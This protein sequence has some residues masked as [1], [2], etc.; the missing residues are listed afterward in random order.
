MSVYDGM[1]DSAAQ[2]SLS[3]VLDCSTCHMT[4]MTTHTI[5]GKALQVADELPFGQ[6]K[7]RELKDAG[8]GDEHCSGAS[9]RDSG[10]ALVLQGI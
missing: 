6:T 5:K 2:P 7:I 8:G 9:Q 10:Q 3:Q 4:L 1:E